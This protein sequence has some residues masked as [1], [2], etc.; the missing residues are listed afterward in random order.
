MSTDIIR[1]SENDLK[2]KTKK[3]KRRINSGY[4]FI[5]PAVILVALISIYPTIRV[6]FLS[7]TNYSRQT[8]EYS[9]VGLDNFIALIESP[10][11]IR[12]LGHTI[13]FSFYSTLGHIGLGFIIA[14][15]MNTNLN[16]TFISVCR[17]LILLPWA[18]SPI[19]VAMIAQIWTHPI[20][21]PVGKAFDLLGIEKVFMP[22]AHPDTAL[23]TLT[24]IN[25]WQF[26]PFYLL[27]ILAALQNIDLELFEAAK[28]DGANKIQQ[29]WFITLPLIKNVLL[30]LILFDSVTTMAFF[31]L[32][33]VTTQ[34]GPVRSTEVLATLIYRSGFMTMDWSR[35]AAA[36]VILLILVFAISI[37]IQII[38][39]K[40]EK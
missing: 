10:I 28:I 14:L 9:Y 21:S 30:T 13:Y 5:G 36:S 29:I 8:L 38:M 31:D 17:A 27:M 19:V 4:F 25:I 33:W 2:S 7:I 39:R 35:A 40:G 24:I 22:L 15:V 16:R 3:T 34:G 6:L 11:F 37:F 20:I 32:I 1:N 18:L 23:A 12:T 26:T